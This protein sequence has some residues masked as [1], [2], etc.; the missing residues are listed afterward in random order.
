MG[1]GEWT[2]GSVGMILPTAVGRKPRR[3]S[4]LRSSV[5]LP[6]AP[7]LSHSLLADKLLYQCTARLGNT[8]TSFSGFCP[9]M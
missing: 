9:Q 4:S 1:K 2:K 3:F 8:P 5:T 7:G 6:H